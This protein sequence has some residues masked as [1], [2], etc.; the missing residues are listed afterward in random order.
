MRFLAT[1]TS[2]V[3]QRIY[4]TPLMMPRMYE[5]P[6]MMLR[7]YVTTLVMPRSWTHQVMVLGQQLNE[8]QEYVT[9]L[10]GEMTACPPREMSV[11]VSIQRG[12][13]SACPP[14]EMIVLM[15]NSAVMLLV[16]M[17]GLGLSSCCCPSRR[18]F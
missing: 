9:I 12:E 1:K 4:A 3:M 13:M 17:S 5:T 2:I 6:L 16:W 7:I 18:S 11:Y 15:L 10:R 14:R 8:F